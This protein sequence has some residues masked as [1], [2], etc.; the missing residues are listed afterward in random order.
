[1]RLAIA[2]PVA[3]TRR[4]G[5]RATAARWADFLTGLGHEVAINPD[6]MEES[7]ALIA[8][9]AWRSAEVIARFRAAH[10][11]RPV[12]VVL[13]GT[14][15]YHF[16]NA[17]PGPT[18]RSLDLADRLVG[19]HDK[20]ADRLPERVRG[21]LRVIHQSAGGGLPGARP[22]PTPSR[23]WSSGTCG[24]KRIRSAR[25]S[26]PGRCHRTPPSAS[27][28]SAAR[29]IPPGSKLCAPRWRPMPAMSGSGTFRLRGCA[30]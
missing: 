1:M 24:R 20:V 18:L 16:L 19:L 4:T 23:C 10:P 22:S 15:L 13:T 5:N 21:K 6:G 12:V 11:D 8:L 2:T 17:E 28:I 9:H 3:A 26:P 7:D 25:P 30:G 27:S 14:D 29:T